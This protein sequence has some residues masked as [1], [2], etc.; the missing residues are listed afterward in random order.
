LAL[1]TSGALYFAAVFGAGCVLG[2]IRVL[3]LAPR[4]GTRA[5]ELMEMPVMLVVI[6]VAARS[7]VRR[8]TVPPTSPERLG[9]GGIALALLVS[10]EVALLPLRGLS[11]RAYWAGLDPVSGAAYIGMLGVYALMPLFVRSAA[12]SRHVRR[13]DA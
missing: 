5:A 2:P 1:L 10:A 4:F 3:W 13:D 6:I 8:R 12:G 9:M 11:P 7:I